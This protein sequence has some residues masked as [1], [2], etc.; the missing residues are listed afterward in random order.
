[1]KQNAQQNMQNK[2]QDAME[3]LQKMNLS[4]DFLFDVAT[5]DLEVCQTIIELALNIRIKKI[6]WKDNQKVIH[7]IPGKRGVR[8][9]F[10]VEDIDGRVFDV[11]MQK[12]NYGNLPKRSRFYQ[13]LVDAPLLDSGAETFDDL[14]PTYIV[15]ICT[16]DLF[17]YQKYRYT[18]EN[19]CREVPDLVLGDE[20]Q[21]VFLNTKG[22]N[23]AEVEQELVDFLHYVDKSSDENV[24]E[25]SDERLKNLHGKLQRIKA[26]KQMGV[27][28]MKMEERDQMI[29][30]EGIDIG[31]RMAQEEINQKDKRIQEL[32][33]ALR[34]AKGEQR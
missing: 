3:R 23:D 7:N 34:V 2:I 17:G 6:A 29:R 18:F 10:Y 9:D 22:S 11:E 16:F 28:Y 30:K 26:D 19:R 4:D 21:K 33:E 5:H 27:S 1:M 15:V 20:S 25:N 32:E 14:N 24:P 12:R 8:L 13:A 31:R